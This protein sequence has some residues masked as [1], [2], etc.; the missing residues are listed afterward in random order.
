M[1]GTRFPN[2]FKDSSGNQITSNLS[3]IT[4]TSASGD[5]DK[6]KLDADVTAL[7]AEIAKIKALIE[8][9]IS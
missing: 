8:K 7:F 1:P 9:L 5:S 2:G 4:K 6:V 3:T